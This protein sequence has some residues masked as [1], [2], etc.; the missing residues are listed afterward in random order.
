MVALVGFCG[1]RSLPSAFSPLVAS[2]VSA[3][4]AA[5]RGASCGRG[6]FFLCGFV[7]WFW[8]PVVCAAFGG[9]GFGGFFVGGGLRFGRFCFCGLSGWFVSFRFGF[10]LLFRFR[11]GFVGFGRF[12]GRARR[13]GCGFSL[14]RF[15]RCGCLGFAAR[16]GGFV[17]LRRFRRLVVGLSFRAFFV[18]RF[19][20]LSCYFSYV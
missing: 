8:S 14:R 3:V 19:A 11:F 15:G 17:G 12:R 9:S 7:V 4:A 5:G 18:A 1:S 2:C 10:A 13:S 16:V 20:F 6:G